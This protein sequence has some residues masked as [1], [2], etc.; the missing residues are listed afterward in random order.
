M[1]CAHQALVSL[2]LSIDRTGISGPVTSFDT[3]HVL[4]DLIAFTCLFISVAVISA[5]RH[6]TTGQTNSLLRRMNINNLATILD[7]VNPVG[8][9]LS[10]LLSS[11]ILLSC[12]LS[13]DAHTGGR[14]RSLLFDIDHVV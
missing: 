14:G 5:A 6:V 13:C 3:N 8:L 2:L 1:L 12:I 4:L 9:T 10:A 7:R 11:D